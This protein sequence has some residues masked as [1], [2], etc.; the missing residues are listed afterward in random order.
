[1]YSMPIYILIKRMVILLK[2][3][4]NTQSSAVSGDAFELFFKF[5]VSKISAW[6]YHVNFP[7]NRLKLL[8][9]NISYSEMPPRHLLT[10]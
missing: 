7:G 2:Y 3:F 6:E 10:E 1:M 9:K 4:C 8:S 5:Y